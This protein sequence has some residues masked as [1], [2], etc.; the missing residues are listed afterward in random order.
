MVEDTFS[1]MN[2]REGDRI[3]RGFRIRQE[4]YGARRETGITNDEVNPNY[5]GDLPYPGTIHTIKDTLD[6]ED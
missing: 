1:Y 2:G 3:S 5:E 6:L 4:A